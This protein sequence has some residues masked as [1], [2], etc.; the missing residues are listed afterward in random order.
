MWVWH[1]LSCKDAARDPTIGLRGPQW[2]DPL[3]YTELQYHQQ[4]VIDLEVSASLQG[5]LYD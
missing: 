1:I 4:C 5:H 3:N 2:C